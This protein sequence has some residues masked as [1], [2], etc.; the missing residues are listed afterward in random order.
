MEIPLKGSIRNSS[1]V[2]ILVYL[3]RNR[4]TGTLSLETPAFTKKVF[5][6]VLTETTPKK[7]SVQVKTSISLFEILS[8]SLSALSIKFF[9]LICAISQSYQ[10]FSIYANLLFRVIIHINK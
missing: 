9:N 7:P 4:K 5:I 6:N 2:K 3:S 10:H 1:L 8:I